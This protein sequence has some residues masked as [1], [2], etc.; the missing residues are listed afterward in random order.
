[1]Q[2]LRAVSFF[3]FIE[4]IEQKLYLLLCYPGGAE[5]PGN[6]IYQCA[7]F[8]GPLVERKLFSGPTGEVKQG[9]TVFGLLYAARVQREECLVK[10]S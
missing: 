3:H 9:V 1:M 8:T 2:A 6:A 10:E 7:L 4:A 5:T